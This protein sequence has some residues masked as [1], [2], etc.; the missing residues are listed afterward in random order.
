MLVE[1]DGQPPMEVLRNMF[2]TLPER[3]VDSCRTPFS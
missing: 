1:L 2:E 3:T